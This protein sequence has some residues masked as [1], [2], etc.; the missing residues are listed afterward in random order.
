LQFVV[1][2]A[3]GLGGGIETRPAPSSPW[4]RRCPRAA[5]EASI[6]HGPSAFDSELPGATPPPSLRL[7]RSRG[8][9]QPPSLLRRERPVKCAAREVIPLEQI[10]DHAA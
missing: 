1:P 6:Q 5:A 4:L 9:P 10:S 2:A 8:M 7:D 3:V